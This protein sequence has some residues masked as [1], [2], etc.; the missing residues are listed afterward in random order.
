VILKPSQPPETARRK[1]EASTRLI[2]ADR[3][4]RP[5][6]GDLNELLGT[7]TSIE[8]SLGMR[9][10]ISTLERMKLQIADDSKNETAAAVSGLDLGALREFSSEIPRRLEAWGIPYAA[11]VRYD[12]NEQ[13]IVAGDQLRAAHGKGVRA[14]LHAA[15][16]L[17]LGQYCFDRD[18]AHPGFV[19]LDS[20]LV[21]YR[22]PDQA[23]AD[24]PTDDEAV[25][26]RVVSSFYDDIQ[27]NFGGQV[28][29]MENTDPPTALYDES[30]DTPFTKLVASG[31]YGFFPVSE[32]ID[33][34]LSSG[35]AA[36]DRTSP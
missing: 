13:D 20:P 10:Q 32:P 30:V 29:L 19:V 26:D 22:P 7:R 31:R 23:Q 14:V 11:T 2:E 8:K 34:L 27:R 15:F 36:T 12:R 1:I 16:T 24:N 17:A 3:A 18:I 21:T 25:D 35:E 9:E 6:R 5:Y 33:P 28:I 4:L